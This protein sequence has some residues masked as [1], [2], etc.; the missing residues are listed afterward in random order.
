MSES[1]AVSGI[2]VGEHSFIPD[3]LTR[4]FE[5]RGVGAL[6]FLTIR[7]RN[8]QVAPQYFYEWARW[9]VERRVYFMFLYTMQNAPEGKDS[10]FTP[11]VVAKI[12]EIAGEY[13]LGDQIGET[14]T[15]YGARPRGYGAKMPAGM[16]DMQSC[17]DTYVRE[18]NRYV[19]IDRKLGMPY[20]APVEATA[21]IRYTFD[22]GCTLALLEMMPGDPEFFV[23][24][25][26]GCSYAF[27]LPLWGT[28]IAQEWYG[29]LRNDDPLKYQRMKA[30]Y[31][32][33]YLAGSHIVCL[34]S[35]DEKIE[36][37]GYVYE[38]EH[39]LCRAYRDEVE[40]CEKRFRENPRLSAEPETRVAFVYGNL[41]AYT[42]WQ[43]TAVWEQYDRD[44]WS[45]GPAE[46]SWRILED[47]RH[48]RTWQEV[49]NYGET[50]LSA[51]PAYGLYDVI[52][53]NTPREKLARYE[54]VIFVGWNTMTEDIWNNL[55]GYVVDGGHL[56]LTAAHLN[57]NSRRDGQ[58]L[59][60]SGGKTAEFLGCDITG[61]NRINTGVKFLRESLREG[62]RYPVIPNG[63]GDPICAGGVM[64]AA[65]LERKGAQTIALWHDD[66]RAPSGEEQTAIVEHAYGRGVVTLQAT[67]DYPGANA[68]YPLYRTVVR[69][70]VT[71]SHRRCD[72]Q[73]IASDKLRFSV[74]RGE[75][76]DMLCLL[77]TDFS[78][79]IT[80][81]VRAYGK[82]YTRTLTPT[83]LAWE[84]L[85]KIK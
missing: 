54:T 84:T 1:F 85:T 52:P 62:V 76:A 4:E 28:Y 74:Y 46:W 23:S 44:E 69:E 81:T 9:C 32:Y 42:G 29:G 14:G 13:F 35:G 16:D 58:Y 65:T 10:Q 63:T 22:A 27:D 56:F 40:A 68:V 21:L 71:A 60:I 49:E 59:P 3:K 24:L 55:R 47:L 61:V 26:R 50:D 73:V 15:L 6:S 39:P 7:T 77:N 83:E 66:F 5:A 19:E 64:N 51:A 30:A 17:R 37:Y 72:V 11:E 2:H 53:A 33:A 36:S 31:R 34:E 20:I 78:N 79:P 80:V 75:H 18:L 12:R 38:Q 70:L 82:T 45:I 57:T 48:A 25:T 43:G 8:Q 41:E 67:V